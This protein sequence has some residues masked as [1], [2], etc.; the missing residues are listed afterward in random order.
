MRS[1]RRQEIELCVR[2]GLKRDRW[3][4]WV[5]SHANRADLRS[6]ILFNKR[7]PVVVL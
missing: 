2:Q 7:P 1:R 3:R 6:M 5:A 4:L